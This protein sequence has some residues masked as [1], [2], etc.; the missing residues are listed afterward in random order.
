MYISIISP[1]LYK[2][3]ALNTKNFNKMEDK[4]GI[5]GHAGRCFGAWR[6][7][8]FSRIGRVSSN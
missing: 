1:C 3:E 5:M 7:G 8:D 4:N 2:G 6:L